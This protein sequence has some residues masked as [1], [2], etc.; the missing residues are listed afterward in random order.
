HSLLAVRLVSHIRSELNRELP[1]TQLFAHPTLQALAAVL[2]EAAPQTL[3]AI[4]PLPDDV[5][6]PL[7][8]AQQ[9][10]WLLT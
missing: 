5:T 9:R 6:P 7:S 1:L 3:S 10:L 2:Q 8:L 4:T